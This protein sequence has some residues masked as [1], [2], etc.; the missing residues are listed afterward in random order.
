MTCSI[1]YIIRSTVINDADLIRRMVMCCWQ[2]KLP[3]TCCW[4]CGGSRKQHQVQ[5][6]LSRAVWRSSMCTRQGQ[7]QE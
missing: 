4:C 3:L 2:A 7:R 5:W 1:L 6:K